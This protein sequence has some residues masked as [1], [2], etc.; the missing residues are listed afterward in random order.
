MS[1]LLFL[2][3][4]MS[5]FAQ[6]SGDGY[7]R[8][9]NVVRGRYIIVLDST[10]WVTFNSGGVDADTYALRT[11]KEKGDN[12]VSNPA[13]ILYIQKHSDG[14][15]F[16]GQGLNT[17]KLS[18]HKLQIKDRGGNKYYAYAE[19]PGLAAVYL[20]D[21]V[22]A[23][24]DSGIVLTSGAKT[25]EWYI[26]PVKST[27]TCYFGFKPTISYNGKYYLT[28][29]ADFPFKT[30]GNGVTVYNICDT[31]KGQ[32]VWK[33]YADGAVVPAAT[34]VV[35]ECSSAEAA[36][37]KVEIVDEK[38]TAISRN[39]LVGCYFCYTYGN[40][41][42]Y[43]YSKVTYDAATM[44]VLGLDSNGKLAFITAKENDLTDGKFITA[45]T[46]YLKV[47]KG[48]AATMPL[49]SSDDPDYVTG[50]TNIEADSQKDKAIYTLSGMRVQSEDNLPHGI[51]IIN[52]K[53]VV[54]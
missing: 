5:A 22:A 14:Y 43:H 13:S 23:T 30:L 3:A 28:F 9:K 38:G 47:A 6:L 33:K 24:Q 52:G 11:I 4:G 32:A 1:L 49:L 45:N 26:Y 18:S 40:G 42:K 54:K 50:I 16:E 35:V 17:A 21:A 36:N 31:F 20:S 10:G 46:A 8:I 7:Y 53:K 51:Y 29:Y 27:S 12:I 25:R 44:R 34:P 48:T 41:Q 15:T 2:V 19:E 39:I 37:N